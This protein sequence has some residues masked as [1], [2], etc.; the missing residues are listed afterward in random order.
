[1]SD[2][3]FNVALRE[4]TCTQATLSNGTYD[5]SF[6][7]KLAGPLSIGNLNLGVYEAET[8]TSVSGN[9][10]SI[11]TP[12][13]SVTATWTGNLNAGDAYVVNVGNDQVQTNGIALS[14]QMIYAPVT[15]LY[16][17]LVGPVLYLQW[18][19]PNCG[20]KPPFY[21]IRLSTDPSGTGDANEGWQVV[22]TTNDRGCGFTVDPSILSGT[23]WQVTVIPCAVNSLGPVATY[24][25]NPTTN[26]PPA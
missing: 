20:F 14:V 16:A 12:T 3:Y 22:T 18:T 19:P 25:F 23:S 4:V 11:A 6:S 9:A 1:M 26:L 15:H 5:V 13:P 21:Q 8:V 10:P 24:R 7:A 17:W 2:V